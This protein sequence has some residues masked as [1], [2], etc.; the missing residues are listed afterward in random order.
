VRVKMQQQ[1]LHGIE[2]KSRVKGIKPRAGSGNE[3]EKYKIH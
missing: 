1:L 2:R 3:L